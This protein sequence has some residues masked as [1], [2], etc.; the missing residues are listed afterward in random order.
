MVVAG[1]NVEPAGAGTS[2]WWDEAA[3]QSFTQEEQAGLACLWTNPSY[4]THTTALHCI[5]QG[6]S[7]LHQHGVA[8]GQGNGL[9]ALPLPGGIGRVGA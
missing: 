9:V 4:A 8:V 7:P 5:L 2:W 1:A 6:I 3:A